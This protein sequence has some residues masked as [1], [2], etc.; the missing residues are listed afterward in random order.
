MFKVVAVIFNV[1][2]TT[3]L[4]TFVPTVT[5]ALAAVESAVCNPTPLKVLNNRTSDMVNAYPDALQF[6]VVM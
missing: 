2:P 6:L 1:V 5:A 3:V 4:E